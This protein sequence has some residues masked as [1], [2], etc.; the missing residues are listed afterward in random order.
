[1]PARYAI[2]SDSPKGRPGGVFHR[3]SDG[4]ADDRSEMPLRPFA[5]ILRRIGGLIF[6]GLFGIVPGSAG[7]VHENRQELAR[8]DNAGQEPS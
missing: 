7:I 3:V 8:N 2:F 5:G 4:V 1:M 6:D